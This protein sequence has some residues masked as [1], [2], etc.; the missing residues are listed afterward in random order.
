MRVWT[1]VLL[2]IGALYFSLG[3]P[4]ARMLCATSVGECC[5][6]HKYKEI[7]VTRWISNL[8]LSQ[9]LQGAMIS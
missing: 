6:P 2:G 1:Q 7:P 3:M 5:C 9:I 4:C 8:E